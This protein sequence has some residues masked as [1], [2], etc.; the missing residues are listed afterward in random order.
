MVGL[1]RRVLRHYAVAAKL[2]PD[3][4]LDYLQ[5]S[6]AEIRTVLEEW[7]NE[8]EFLQ[9]AFVVC[10][11]GARIV[12]GTAGT[13]FPGEDEDPPMHKYGAVFDARPCFD[14]IRSAFF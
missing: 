13:P 1:E 4:D 2:L 7:P 11:S 10:A 8:S 12:K 5:M 9:Q 3:I 14:A 6:E